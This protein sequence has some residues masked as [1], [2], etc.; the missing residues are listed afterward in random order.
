MLN[1]RSFSCLTYYSSSPLGIVFE[2]SFKCYKFDRLR[3]VLCMLFRG[4]TYTRKY[5]AFDLTDKL[6]ILSSKIAC[7][8]MLIVVD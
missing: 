7:A 5:V 6:Y 1:G 3:L 8:S 4:F 2:E